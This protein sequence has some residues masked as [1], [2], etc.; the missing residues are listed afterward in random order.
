MRPSI[1]NIMRRFDRIVNDESE[2]S[3]QIADGENAAGEG[4]EHQRESEL[5]RIIERSLS[6]GGALFNDANFLSSS[7]R[8]NAEAGL[9]RAAFIDAQASDSGIDEIEDLNESNLAAIQQ[10]MIDAGYSASEI[11]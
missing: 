2:N 9:D 3:A 1:A 5:S 6:R 4:L 7:L 8:L 10:E 11:R